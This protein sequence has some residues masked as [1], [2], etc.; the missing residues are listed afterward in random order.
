MSSARDLIVPI[1]HGARRLNILLEELGL[2]PQ[3]SGVGGGT[4][5]GS[6]R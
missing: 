2:G 3:S 4:R 1:L 6:V 5:A